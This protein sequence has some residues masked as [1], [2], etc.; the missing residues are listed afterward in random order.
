MTMRYFTRM[1]LL[2]VNVANEMGHSFLLFDQPVFSD[3]LYSYSTSFR[4]ELDLL[5]KRWQIMAAILRISLG[6]R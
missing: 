5:D 6:F 2:D 1:E 3:N 4:E